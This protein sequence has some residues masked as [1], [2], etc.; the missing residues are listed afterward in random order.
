MPSFLL[1]FLS[2]CSVSTSIHKYMGCSVEYFCYRELKMLM[3]TMK[4]IK[5]V[6]DCFKFR[7]IICLEI[8]CPFNANGFIFVHTF[9]LSVAWRSCHWRIF[10]DQILFSPFANRLC[11]LVPRK[12]K[13]SVQFL[14][15]QKWLIFNIQY[16]SLSLVNKSSTVTQHTYKQ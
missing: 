10:V 1:H 13:P 2:D 15:N 6:L 12:T 4:M 8:P 11:N 16:P 7:W 3:R 14:R 9:R 5:V